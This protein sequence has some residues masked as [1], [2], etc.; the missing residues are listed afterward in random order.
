MKSDIHQTRRKKVLEGVVS[1]GKSSV[2]QKNKGGS[3]EANIT[4]TEIEGGTQAPTEKCQGFPVQPTGGTLRPTR[5]IIRK[6]IGTDTNKGKDTNRI[7]LIRTEGSRH[8]DLGI[9]FSESAFQIRN[10]FLLT[11]I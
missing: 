5:K 4:A 11:K 10:F 1:A 3:P 8:P 2:T 6:K 9:Y 7:E